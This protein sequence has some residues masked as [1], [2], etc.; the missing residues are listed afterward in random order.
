[1]HYPTTQQLRL[2]VI[3][4][5][6]EVLSMRTRRHTQNAH[7]TAAHAPKEF[8][9]VFSHQQYKGETVDY[10]CNITQYNSET[11][12]SHSHT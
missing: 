10:S 9:N 6:E 4:C 1:M 12:M 7:I 11:S 2:E 3:I 5:S 8:N